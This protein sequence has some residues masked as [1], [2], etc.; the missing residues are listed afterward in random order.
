MSTPVEFSSRRPGRRVLAGEFMVTPVKPLELGVRGHG[1]K[2]LPGR[3]RLARDHW[4]VRERPEWFKPADPK[5]AATAERRPRPTRAHGSST[6]PATRADGDDQGVDV[7]PAALGP[8]DELSLAMTSSRDPDGA[9]RT[10]GPFWGTFHP[11]LWV[12]SPGHP[13]SPSRSSAQSTVPTLRARRVS[14]KAL[15]VECEPVHS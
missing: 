3:D 14:E 2:L 13:M 11:R 7:P 6:P 12:P 15:S 1:E 4:A 8:R 9:A 10:G 5:D